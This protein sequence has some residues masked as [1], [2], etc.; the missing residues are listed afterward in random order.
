[1]ANRYESGRGVGPVMIASGSQ[2]MYVEWNVTEIV[3]DWASGTSPNYG[4]LLRNLELGPN[5]L[6]FGNRE[7]VA[8]NRPRLI[9][10]FG[11]P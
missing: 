10:E 8:A 3:R 6:H 11:P 2:R 9:V 4:F 7:D 1:M 5:L